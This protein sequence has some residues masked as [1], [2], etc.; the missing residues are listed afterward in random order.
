MAITYFIIYIYTARISIYIILCC[1]LGITWSLHMFAVSMFNDLH[2]LLQAR[3]V[4]PFDC[5]WGNIV[6]LHRTTRALPDEPH[7]P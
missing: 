3:F 1:L 2:K 6:T 5:Q 7:D 4:W